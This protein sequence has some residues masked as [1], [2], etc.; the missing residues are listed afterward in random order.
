[1]KIRLDIRLIKAAVCLLAGLA[2]FLTGMFF[3]RIWEE[4]H[5]RSETAVANE[6]INC[7]PVDGIY[8]DHMWYIPRK[9]IQTMLLL[10]IDK[11]ADADGRQ[12]EHGEYEQADFLLLLVMDLKAHTCTAIHLNRDTMTDIRMISDAGT[13]LGMYTGQ[14][15]LAHAYGLDA[16]MRCQNTVRAVSDL[17]YGV[18][19]DHYLSL[20]MDGVA[21]LNDLVGGVTVEMLED[22]SKIDA[23]LAKGETV[24]LK[25]DQALAYVRRRLDIGDGSNLSRMKRQEQY[26][27]ALQEKLLQ[28]SDSDDNFISST[29]LEVNDYMV[30]DCSVNQLSAFSEMLREYGVSEYLTLEGETVIGEE[31]V[32]FYADE[33]ALQKLV[34]SLFYE[35]MEETSSDGD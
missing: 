21:V 25:G 3:F 23:S 9:D 10:G 8:Y 32:E 29:L 17:L 33:D 4:G 2:L 20:A 11:Y 19:I 5:S 24:T 13:L 1:M 6:E 34:V 18:R 31:H 7:T 14:L 12:D 22:F 35:P 26:L 16:K 15:T 28:M 27:E 30:S